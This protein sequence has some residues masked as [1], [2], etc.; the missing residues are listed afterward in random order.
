MF[1]TPST[2]SK[3]KPWIP[4]A[5]Q[6]HAASCLNQLLLQRHFHFFLH[7]S[8]TELPSRR[9]FHTLTSYQDD[10]VYHPKQ[11]F[12]SYSGQLWWVL[13]TNHQRRLL[14]MYL[15]RELLWINLKPWN[16]WRFSP[17]KVSR[18]AAC[19]HVHGHHI[20]MS[21]CIHESTT[22]ICYIDVSFC[23][24]RGDSWCCHCV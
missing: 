1:I 14:Y 5:L 23:L 4:I 17:S 8:L 3:L 16:S 20:Y 12:S 6:C 24:S 22:W 2:A 15:M 10:Y 11:L 7:N 19:V 13:C 9:D 21:T 18:Y